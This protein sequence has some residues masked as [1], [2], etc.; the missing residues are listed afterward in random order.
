MQPL[1][2]LTIFLLTS[3]EKRSQMKTGWTTTS[4]EAEM[5]SLVGSFS[6]IFHQLQ[7]TL[8]VGRITR[9]SQAKLFK[10]I[11]FWISVIDLMTQERGWVRKDRARGRM[12]RSL[13]DLW[14]YFFQLQ[15]DELKAEMAQS[16][17]EMALPTS[18]H[19][20]RSLDTITCTP[21]IA[22]ISTK[23]NITDTHSCG[24]AVGMRRNYFLH[25]NLSSDVLAWDLLWG[26]GDG[27]AIYLG[28][29]LGEKNSL[30][31]LSV[32]ECTLS[33]EYVQHIQS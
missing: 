11:S 23:S 32:E 30:W 4:G 24:R 18:L 7:M 13:P 10:R 21:I 27:L 29:E 19:I 14:W 8:W 25:Q 5:T 31:R 33:W 3:R 15:V 2:L 17:Q 1:P 6:Q 22:T 28:D 9:G 20:K 12:D 26:E 16:L